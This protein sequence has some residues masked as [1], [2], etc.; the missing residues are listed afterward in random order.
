MGKHVASTQVSGTADQV[1]AVVSDGNR[2]PDWLS[3][4]GVV[5]SIEPAGALAKGSKLEASIGNIG[6][7]K[8][9]IKEAEAGKRLKWSAGPFI[10]HMMRMPMIVELTLEAR[11]ESTTA[12]IS[13]GSNPM[14]AP[15]MGMMTGLKFA[16]EAPKTVQALKAAVE[17][18]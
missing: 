11:G 5:D 4:V 10:A 2:L 14:M 9:N 3:P 7:A 8:L 6:G 18:G 12:T 16:D 15:I 1:W 17:K 13:Y